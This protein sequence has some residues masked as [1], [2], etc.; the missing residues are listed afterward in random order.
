MKNNIIAKKMKE[1]SIDEDTRN[2]IAIDKILRESTKLHKTVMIDP[3]EQLYVIV[4][5]RRIYLYPKDIIHIKFDTMIIHDEI[6]NN[7]CLFSHKAS[8][9]IEIKDQIFRCKYCKTQIK[10]TICVDNISMLKI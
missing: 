6:K 10:G 8:D 7:L 1:K 9:N 4:D 2:I 3:D 5:N